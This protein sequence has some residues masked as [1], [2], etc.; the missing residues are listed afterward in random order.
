MVQAISRLI[1]EEMRD[2]LNNDNE[3][4]HY[5][6]VGHRIQTPESRE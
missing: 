3:N 6:I 2:N 5:T 4:F 1:G